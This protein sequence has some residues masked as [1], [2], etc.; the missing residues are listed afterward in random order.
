M[1]IY[2][3]EK[4]V[5]TEHLDKIDEILSSVRFTQNADWIG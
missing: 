4:P 3:P 1:G 5:C 2:A